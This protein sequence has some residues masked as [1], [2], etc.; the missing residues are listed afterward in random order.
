MAA[1]KENS[2]HG[3]IPLN[4]ETQTPILTKMFFNVLTASMNIEQ[5]YVL[6]PEEALLTWLVK[7]SKKDYFQDLCELVV[8]VPIGVYSTNDSLVDNVIEIVYDTHNSGEDSFGKLLAV[9]SFVS[10][11]I[12]IILNSGEVFIWKLA[13]KLAGFYTEQRGPWLQSIGGI[14]KGLKTKF[15]FSW[16][17]FFLKQKWLNVFRFHK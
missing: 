14:H 2:A 17:F 12:E 5:A 1:T 6:S 9:L 15:P 3:D 8:Q 7:E 11:Y 10:C 4:M 16:K 13:K